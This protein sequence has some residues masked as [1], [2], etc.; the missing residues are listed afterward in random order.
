MK[1][2][3]PL[4]HDE[5]C[6]RRTVE[7]QQLTPYKFFTQLEALLDKTQQKG[8]GSVFLTQKR[9]MHSAR[10]SCVPTLISSSI[11]RRLGDESASRNKGSRRSALGPQPAEPF[12]YP[13]PSH[14]RR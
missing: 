11:A 4:S 13:H 8:H 9:C 6:A 12:A 1:M 2:G 14:R 5:V 10:L 7:E 3:G